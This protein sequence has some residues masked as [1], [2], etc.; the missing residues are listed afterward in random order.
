MTT[1]EN[2]MFRQFEKFCKENLIDKSP[3]LEPK[4][5]ENL[6]D[7]ELG[8]RIHKIVEQRDYLLYLATEMVA[9]LLNPRNEKTVSLELRE[10]A[11][12]SWKNQLRS[13]ADEDELSDEDVSF[14]LAASGID[15]T[16]AVK[17]IHEL[18]AKKK[19]ENK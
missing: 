8:E 11:E 19:K 7:S 6:N 10:L 2:E 17:R 9:T 5:V 1:H 4:K 16:E 15:C 12:I 13:A 18:V 3:K 14:A